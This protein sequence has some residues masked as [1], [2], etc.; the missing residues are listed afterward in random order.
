MLRVN[1]YKKVN[2]NLQGSGLLPVSPAKLPGLYT[3]NQNPKSPKP[4]RIVKSAP[5]PL[6]ACK[7]SVKD[8]VWELNGVT[9][10]TFNSFWVNIP[11]Q[12]YTILKTNG[13]TRR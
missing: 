7:Q 10:P 13:N 4:K 3:F 12:S 11:R 2:Y 8:N 6:I 5:K 9:Y 1:N